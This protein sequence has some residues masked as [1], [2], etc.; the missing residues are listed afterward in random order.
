MSLTAD[1]T[2]TQQTQRDGLAH[3]TEPTAVW[4]VEKNTQS[5]QLTA[6]TDMTDMATSQV[7]GVLGL[8][9]SDKMCTSYVT[10]T[11]L[12]HP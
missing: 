10:V 3:N 4:P 7:D 9:T 11:I 6:T 8:P 5:S 1:S 2:H 12:V